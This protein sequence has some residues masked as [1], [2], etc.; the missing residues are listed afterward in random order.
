M[1]LFDYRCKHCHR[2]VEVLVPS[3]GLPTLSCVHDDCPG[4]RDPLALERDGLGFG[5][6]APSPQFK[7]SGWARDGYAS[8]SVSSKKP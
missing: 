4:Q 5:S 3:G 6:A 1:P 7:G 2:T 8:S